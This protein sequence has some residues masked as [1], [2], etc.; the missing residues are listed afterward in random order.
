MFPSSHQNWFF[1]Q[2]LFCSTQVFENSKIQTSSQQFFFYFVV[3][4]LLRF[5]KMLTQVKFAFLCENIA[6]NAPHN[7]HT[8][9]HTSRLT[10]QVYQTPHTSYLSHT[11]RL[12]PHTSR[13]TQHTSPL[14]AHM[15]CYTFR[16][17]IHEVQNQYQH[18]HRQTMGSAISGC[19][20]Y[21]F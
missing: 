17:S 10:P 1:L 2:Q 15:T 12:N 21:K 6:L 18:N 4:T 16:R 5:Q 7:P 13:L 14:S 9:P 8:S 19:I 3:D 20:R 11:S